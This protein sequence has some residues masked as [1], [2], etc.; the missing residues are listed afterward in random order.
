METVDSLLERGRNLWTRLQRRFFRF[1]RGQAD[2]N[3]WN[4]RL[5]HSLSRTR[6]PSWRQVRHLPEVL[7]SND[8]LR[9]Q[10]G[11]LLVLAGLAILGVRWYYGSTVIAPAVGG[12][13]TE[14]VVG[15]PHSLNPVLA[16]SN[17]VDM[18]LTRL[19]YSS[20]YTTDK[21]GTIV[22]DLVES[23][24]V[25]TDQKTYVLKLREAKWHDGAP[26]TADDV[27]FTLGLLQDP[28]W[29]SP[30]RT[31]FAGVTAGKIDDRTVQFAIKEPLLSF[32]SLLTFGI[33][34]QHVWKNVA[35]ADALQTE[36]NLKPIGSGP[37]A[38]DSIERDK[39]GFILAYNL[40]RN[41]DYYAQPPY[42]ERMRFQFYPDSG[43]ALDGL[44]RHDVDSLSYVPRDLI[45]ELKSIGAVTPVS[46]ELPQV[47]AIF[48]NSQENGALGDKTVRRA[49]AEAI[50][51]S[52]L[53]LDVLHGE[54]RPLDN[55]P[56]PGYV[57]TPGAAPSFDPV[58]AGKLLDA[59]GWK[60][61]TDG[62]RKK[63][64]VATTTVKKTTTSVTTKTPLTI[65]LTIVD[66]P[67]SNAAAQVIKESW[68]AVGVAVE[69]DAVSPADVY[70]SRIQ[71]RDY[72]ALLYGQLMGPDD[73][74]YPY[75]HST[76]VADPGLNLA[77]FANRQADADLEAAR[78][79]ADATERAGHL[80]DFI[81]ILNDQVPAVFL[82]SP[83]YT[84]PLP[85]ALKG[86]GGTRINIPADRF[87]TVTSWYLK[88]K[89]VWK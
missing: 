58:A 28:A 59:A 9:L 8:N 44:K 70:R 77:L 75:W 83:V 10:L 79:S 20:L 2:K 19:I 30:L 37:F 26:V 31:E 3:V 65:K 21:D 1:R 4:R 55:P 5:V 36:V 22:P 39:R 14:G 47:T 34:P 17:D 56:L 82:Y 52:R 11:A 40:K 54:G 6:L 53:L 43:A 41:P 51:K 78:K 13:F 69:I 72:E 71:P 33:L 89:R 45:A 7:S 16:V 23:E 57:P 76:Q 32:R 24:T 48:F 50:N 46:L 66:Q 87:A 38:F 49:L 81:N 80:T 42:L 73:D 29:K 60:L 15:S 84:Y 61:D 88:T 62:F 25:S 86:F 18:D 68:N 64:S 12:T 35:P 27:L 63:T 67:E 85:A 74:P